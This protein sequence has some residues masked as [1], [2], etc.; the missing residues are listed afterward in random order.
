MN[1]IGDYHTHTIYSHG[2]GTIRDNVEEAFKKGLKEIAICDHG[3]GHFTYGIKRED[4]KKMRKEIDELNKEFQPKGL[5]ILL[6]VEANIIRYDGTIDVDDEI[7]EL[8]DILL[9]G[10]HFGAFPGTFK[11]GYKL[12]ILNFLSK[13]IPKVR[14]NVMEMNTLALIK[15]M[16]RY[17]IDII[18][19]PGSKVYVDIRRLARKAKEKDIALEINSSHSH[20]TVEEIELALEEDVYFYINS[21]AHSPENVGNLENGIERALKGKVPV[22]RIKNIVE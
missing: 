1:I 20:L 22:D 10:Y 17:P 6:G 11:D 2:K 5:K 18:T 12:Y 13:V 19:H 14:K 3:P 21:D 4:I 15:A 7:I 8:L 9:L 16:D